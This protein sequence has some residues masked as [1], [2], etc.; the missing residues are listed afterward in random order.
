M[1][2][3]CFAF[4]AA[5][6][7]IAGVFGEAPEP[8]R[9]WVGWLSAVFFGACGAVA[10]SRLFDDD[11]QLRISGS[12]I[13][14]SQWSEQTIPWGAIAEV[15]VVEFKRHKF[16]NLHLVRPA[17]YPSTTLSGKMAKA[18][19]MLTGGDIT[20]NLTGMD[21]GFD[22]VFAAI[23]YFRRVHQRPAVLAE[24]SYRGFGRRGL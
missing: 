6:L 15:S 2:L 18:N 21:C 20:I 11:V 7:W 13:Y 4:V 19:R 5:G 23:E 3:G 14:Y 17:L 9:E 1:V 8:G 10:C 22:E 16:L 12:G 24:Q